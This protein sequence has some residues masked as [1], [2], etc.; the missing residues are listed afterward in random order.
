MNIVQ[1]IPMF[2]LAG[3]ETMCENLTIELCR[4]GNNV[5][6]ISL[7][8]Y[9]SSITERIESAGIHIYYLGKKKGLDLTVI[10]KII[11]IFKDLK[12]DVVHSHLYAIK[13]AAISATL[14]GVKCIVHTMHNIATKET[15]AKGQF[16]NK[17]LFKRFHVIPVSLSKEIQNTV[18]ERYHIGEKDLPIIFNGI[19][20]N[21]CVPKLNYDNKDNLKYLHIGRF[22]AQKNHEMLIDA[23]S[24]VHARLP[25][26]ELS[27]IGVGELEDR[28][29]QQVRELGLMNSVRFLG[30]QDNVFP[31]LTEADIFVLSSKYEGMP[32]TIIEAMGTGIPVVST[33]VGGVSSII[34]NNINGVLTNVS[35]DDFANAMFS[36][37]DWEY[38]KRIGIAAV[39]KIKSCF[40]VEAMADNYLN[41][42]S[43]SQ[44]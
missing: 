18:I 13:Y 6:V 25:K 44:H 1:V 12:P 26:A 8:D 34:D 23:F 20:L 9:H 17:I 3:A 32:M 41:L 5:N 7:Y 14:C 36:L 2:G 10:P 31:F 24:L 35:T 37:S 29:K 30:L 38:R 40:T 42:Y 28:V 43:L 22:T 21:K 19:D 16:L 33:N 4:R 27:L 39:N 11:R 15:D